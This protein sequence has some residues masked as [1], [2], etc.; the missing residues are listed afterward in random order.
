MA[1]KGA[2]CLGAII[3]TVFTTLIA[4]IVVSLVT[5]EGKPNEGKAPAQAQARA[6]AGGARAVPSPSA[7]IMQVIAQ[8]VGWSPEEAVQDALRNALRSAAAAHFDADTWARQGAALFGALLRET[9][10]LIARY[11]DLR[12]GRGLHQGRE[13][14]H[15]T[16]AVDVARRP[17]AD[18]LRGAALT[19]P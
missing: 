16:L 6:G 11:Q 15:T 10:G 2:S 8:G 9:R 13:Y 19:T 12:S 5:A 14:Y 3:S 18:R 4:P 17:L 7:E 1:A